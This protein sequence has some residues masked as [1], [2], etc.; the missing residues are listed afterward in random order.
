M[1]KNNNNNKQRVLA[2]VL[3]LWVCD[4]DFQ[5]KT[6][7]KSA[8]QEENEDQFKCPPKQPAGIF[9]KHPH[10]EDCRQ[11]FVCIGGTPREYGC[12]LGTVFKVSLVL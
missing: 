7:K 5:V 8:S 11:Y 2:L 3:Y 12:P 10:P 4:I 9:T 1:W 6:C